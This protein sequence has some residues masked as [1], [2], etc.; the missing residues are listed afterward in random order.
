VDDRTLVARF[1]DCSLSGA[2]LG[3]REHVRI[4]WIYLREA[5]FE[6]AAQRFCTHL[7][8]FA[9]ALG[10]ADRYHATITWAYLALVH[11]RI[12]AG[13][14]ANDFAA[15]ADANPDL[16]M[17]ENGALTA[18]YDEATLASPLARQVFVLPR[19]RGTAGQEP[20]AAAHQ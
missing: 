16:M 15:F 9:A 1:E 4:A 6:A 3:H 13:P 7:R 2:E 17:R 10:K 11:E 14:P 5:P 8:R 20:P 18:Y 19:P 12:H